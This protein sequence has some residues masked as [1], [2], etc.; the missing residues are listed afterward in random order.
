MNMLLQNGCSYYFLQFLEDV[1]SPVSCAV[2]FT[3][4]RLVCFAVLSFLY[5]ISL[6]DTSCALS[7]A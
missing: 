3:E 4:R 6:K 2:P 1:K 5:F 7:R